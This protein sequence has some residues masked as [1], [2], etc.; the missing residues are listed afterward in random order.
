MR[1]EPL[2]A[3][4]PAGLGDSDRLR[5]WR[6]DPVTRAASRNTAEATPDE[7]AA[8]LARRL[9]DPDTRI[10][11]VEHRG[12]PSGT[13]RVDRLAG[14]RGEIH[15]SLAPEARGHRLAA[16]AL[17]AAARRGAAE[18]GLATIEA[19]VREDNVPSLRAFARAGFEPAGRDGD[20]VILVWRP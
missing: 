14:D 2:V 5:E 10:F 18:L 7:H 11:I 20:F 12:E 16:P 9:G 1:A 15:V 4:R 3:L 13:V 6:N 8:W 19:T 17:R